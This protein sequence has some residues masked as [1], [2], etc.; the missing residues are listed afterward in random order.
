MGIA[1]V[2][3]LLYLK[4]WLPLTGI[5]IPCVFREITGL[6]CPGCGLTRMVLALMELDFLQAFRYNM[7]IFFVAPLF[8]IY[9]WLAR[10]GK[11]KRASVLMGIMIVMAIVFGVLRNIPSFK[12]LAPTVI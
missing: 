2:G 10:S 7:L 6:W 1:G 11:A 5:E 3:G 8:I 12:W 4:V 9:L